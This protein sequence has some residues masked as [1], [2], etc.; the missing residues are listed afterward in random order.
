MPDR[1]LGLK[2]KKR[3]V[4]GDCAFQAYAAG[5]EE[6][7]S[8]FVLKELQRITYLSEYETQLYLRKVDLKLLTIL[9]SDSA[10]FASL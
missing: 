4:P 1:S 6:K 7:R 8:G 10:A 9:L 3:P 2:S 5:Y